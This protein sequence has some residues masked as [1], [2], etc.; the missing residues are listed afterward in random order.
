MYK[1]RTINNISVAGLNR[2]PREHYEV[3]SEITQPDAI[4]VRSSKL[5]A[6]ELPG[7]LVAIGRAGARCQQHPC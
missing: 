3:A 2:L 4:L 6:S 7:S 1:V 5:N